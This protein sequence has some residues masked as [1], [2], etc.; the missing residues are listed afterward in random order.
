VLVAFTWLGSR[1]VGTELPLAIESGL[2]PTQS[3]GRIWQLT[4]GNAWRILLVLFITTLVTLPIQVFAQLGQTLAELAARATGAD[5]ATVSIMSLIGSLILS[6]G[7]GILVMPLW[8]ITKSVIY[9]DLQVRREGLG[10]G[11]QDR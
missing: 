2:T 4:K 7:L 8:Q 9:R 11:L 5:S 1:L 6:Y 3:I 10:L